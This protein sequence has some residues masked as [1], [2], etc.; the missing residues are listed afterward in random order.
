MDDVR[1]QMRVAGFLRAAAHN[2]DGDGRQSRNHQLVVR[3]ML[4]DQAA[5]GLE[6]YEF[7]LR[8][9]CW[10]QHSLSNGRRNNDL[11]R[12]LR[13]LMHIFSGKMRKLKRT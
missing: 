1:Q 11:T 13:V 9:D 2:L 3:D 10:L 8:W 5:Y 7:S 12:H 6:V 4:L